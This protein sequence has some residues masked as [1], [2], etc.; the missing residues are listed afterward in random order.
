MMLMM[1]PW[2]PCVDEDVSAVQGGAAYLTD[3]ERRLA[4]YVERA[5]PRQ[6][7]LAYLKGL[8]SPA[9]RKNSWPLAEIG[10]DATP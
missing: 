7:A 4:P 2:A 5:E 9:A 3:I 8:L 10:G 6:R 1:E